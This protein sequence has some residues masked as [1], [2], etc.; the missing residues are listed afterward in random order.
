MRISPVF[1][2]AHARPDRVEAL[3]DLGERVLL[4]AVMGL[5]VFRFV[6]ATPDHPINLLVVI[7]E[8]LVILFVLI[9]RAGRSVHSGTAWVAALVGT[10]APLFVAP[11]GTTMQPDPAFAAAFEPVAMVVMVAG[12]TFS[13]GAKLFLRRSFGI[14]AANRG[15]QQRGPYR[16]VRHPMYLGYLLCHAAFLSVSLSVWNIAVYTACWCAMI[17]RIRLEEGILGED[18][19]YRAYRREVRHR[20][21]PGIW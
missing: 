7:S 5:L 12:M 15:V 17:L 18:A 14:V 11:V 16:V 21:I 20:L 13:I 4:L 2:P 10:F 3:L 1:D 8:S 9:R 19:A 6:P